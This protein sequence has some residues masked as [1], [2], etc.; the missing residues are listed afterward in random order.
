MVV[1]AP[2]DGS[3][4]YSLTC[5]AQTFLPLTCQAPLGNGDYAPKGP[6]V[7]LCIPPAQQRDRCKP[8]R[9]SCGP[10]FKTQT[11]LDSA[12]HPWFRVNT[13]LC[14][15]GNCCFWISVASQKKGKISSK[16]KK[17][18][19]TLRS[20]ERDRGDNE[21]KRELN[22]EMRWGHSFTTQ[23]SSKVS[24]TDG[25]RISDLVSWL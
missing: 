19:P 13:P 25:Q 2:C 5:V 18:T 3:M 4:K 20:Y 21:G 12:V 22:P 24:G 11:P 17:A 8:W 7:V 16:C 9:S 1:N 14:H 10:W 23:R 15:S 6:V